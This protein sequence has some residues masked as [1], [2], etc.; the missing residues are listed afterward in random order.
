MVR[1]SFQN[2]TSHNRKISVHFRVNLCLPMLSFW[3]L[4]KFLFLVCSFC[5]FLNEIGIDYQS[6]ASNQQIIK[7]SIM[8]TVRWNSSFTRAV[9]GG[10]F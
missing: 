8:A 9:E 4:L 5:A 2:T 3:G 7:N 6:L 10:T 1:L